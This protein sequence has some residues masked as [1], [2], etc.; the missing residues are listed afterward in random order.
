MA[1]GSKSSNTNK[2]KTPN[3]SGNRRFENGPRARLGIHYLDDDSDDGGIPPNLSGDVRKTLDKGSPNGKEA[4][5]SKSSKNVSRQRTSL[6]DIAAQPSTS[7]EHFS[8]RSKDQRNFENKKRA[9]FMK[10]SPNNGN[11]ACFAS[12]I[13]DYSN[14]AS[15]HQIPNTKNQTKNNKKSSS[16]T[17]NHSFN[18]ALNV[19]Q[20]EGDARSEGETSYRTFSRHFQS[21][22]NKR[23]SRNLP[24][25]P[26]TSASQGESC[27]SYSLST[28]ERFF[29]RPR[30][31]IDK[32]RGQ[33]SPP[34]R[35][36]PPHHRRQANG[37]NDAPSSFIRNLVHR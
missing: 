31:P 7:G 24:E 29:P 4:S 18:G 11:A 13:E 22:V 26:E 3:Y 9:L 21:P 34:R 19:H 17:R 28:D 23:S 36:N 37:R 6:P 15:N 20:R 12:D 5:S 14:S 35:Q 8:T 27:N 10:K 1:S 33:G 25:M 16:T 30:L 2:P 32:Y